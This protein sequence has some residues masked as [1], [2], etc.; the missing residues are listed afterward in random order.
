MKQAALI[1]ALLVR[2]LGDVANVD[3]AV[4]SGQPVALRELPAS[5][6]ATCP[7][8]GNRDSIPASGALGS[9]PF[10]TWTFTICLGPPGHRG[11][12]GRSHEP[13]PGAAAPFAGN[14]PA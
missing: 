6:S 11:R 14:K 5:R 4:L 9:M 12:A 8:T 13:V 1:L 3:A 7:P 10:P 2:V